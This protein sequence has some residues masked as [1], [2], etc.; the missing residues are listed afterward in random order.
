MMVVAQQQQLAEA[1]RGLFA[2]RNLTLNAASQ[3]FGLDRNAITR[4]WHGIPASLEFTERFA[5]TFRED[6]NRWR[7]LAGYEPVF[8]PDAALNEGIRRIRE[9]TGADFQVS[10]EEFMLARQGPEAVERILAAV[11]ARLEER[12]R[13]S[14]PAAP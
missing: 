3:R 11:R 13:K 7:E 9:E 12:Q 10:A 6:V 2:R 8:S 1:A 14:T 4:M 5:R